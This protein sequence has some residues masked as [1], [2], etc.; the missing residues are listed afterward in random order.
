M[1]LSEEEEKGDLT[2]KAPLLANER[3]LTLGVSFTE[4]GAPMAIC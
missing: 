4:T 1:E 3:P 2:G